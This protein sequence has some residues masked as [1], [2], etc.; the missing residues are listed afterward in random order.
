M[1]TRKLARTSRTVITFSPSILR[2]CIPEAIPSLSALL[3]LPYNQIDMSCR[4]SPHR[5]SVE[6]HH[7]RLS[8]NPPSLRRINH[9]RPL[10]LNPPD[11]SH[12]PPICRPVP[13]LA[14]PLPP[15]SFF[16]L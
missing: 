4:N 2:N 13:Q 6:N 10:W 9:L 3:Y 14:S 16:L 5:T 8:R 15:R 11:L 7:A 1:N 12:N